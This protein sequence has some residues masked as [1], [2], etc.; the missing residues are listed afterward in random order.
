MLFDSTKINLGKITVHNA[1]EASSFSIGNT[2]KVTRYVNAKK[3]QAFGQQFADQCISAGSFYKNIDN[4]YL[5]AF[6]TKSDK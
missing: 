1:D 6:S 2:L 3:N 5:D 4:D